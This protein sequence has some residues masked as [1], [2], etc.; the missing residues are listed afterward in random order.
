VRSEGSPYCRDKA[1]TVFFASL[2]M[3]DF[4]GRQQ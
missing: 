2:R 3:T 4:P 1:N